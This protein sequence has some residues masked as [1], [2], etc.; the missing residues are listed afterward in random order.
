MH[1]I[2]FTLLV[3]LKPLDSLFN[4]DNLRRQGYYSQMRGVIEQMYEQNNQTKVTLVAHSMGGPVSLYFLN[5]VVDQ[6]WKDQYVHAFIPLS[7]A[8]DG[9]AEMLEALL[10]ASVNWWWEILIPKVIMKDY[11][12]LFRT[13]QGSFWMVPSSDSFGSRVIAQVG[14]DTYTTSQYSALFQRA[15]M[16]VGFTKYTNVKGI[17]SGWPAPNVPTHCFYG[18]FPGKNNTPETFIYAAE[19]FPNNDPTL[20]LNGLGDTTVNAQI[21]EI[22]LR[23]MNQ[24]ANFTSRTFEVTHSNM[25]TDASVLGAIGQIVGAPVNSYSLPSQ[26]KRPSAKLPVE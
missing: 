4:A 25:I 15:E 22:C 11:R 6:A 20:V 13:F 24:S 14:S 5:N 17:N 10:S 16:G 23:W 1:H 21:S 3:L 18:L 26:R 19:G 8:W 9:A 7:G 12:D 2:E